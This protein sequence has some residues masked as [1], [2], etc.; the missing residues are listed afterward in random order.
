MT[1]STDNTLAIFNFSNVM[2]YVLWIRAY[3]LC[4]Q[5]GTQQQHFTHRQH[6]EGTA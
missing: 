3:I 6:E 4:M 2:R 1:I 5:S